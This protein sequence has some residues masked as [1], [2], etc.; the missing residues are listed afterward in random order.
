MVTSTGVFAFTLNGIDEFIEVMVKP[1]D[2]VFIV[3]ILALPMDERLSTTLKV[4]LGLR[5]ISGAESRVTVRLLSLE[6]GR[7]ELI[8]IVPGE[9][10]KTQ[11]VPTETR[12]IMETA[13]K[14]RR[15]LFI[16]RTIFARLINIWLM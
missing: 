1:G 5:D 14:A 10:Y 13:I 15:V 9:K 16:E 7:M 6:R 8:F 4:S 11:T 3:S 2:G 12:I